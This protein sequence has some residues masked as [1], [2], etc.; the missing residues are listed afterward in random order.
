MIFHLLDHKVITSQAPNYHAQSRKLLIRIHKEPP[1]IPLFRAPCCI[2]MVTQID[3]GKHLLLWHDMIICMPANIQKSHVHVII[4]RKWMINSQQCSGLDNDNS[5]QT[6]E[7]I[8]FCQQQKHTMSIAL[9]WLPCK[10]LKKG[11][12]RFFQETVWVRESQSTQWPC[13][14]CTSSHFISPRCLPAP[15]VTSAAAAQAAPLRRGDDQPCSSHSY[16]CS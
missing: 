14:A 10:Q 9:L 2:S 13:T 12:D 5:I 1:V 3:F 4:P 8:N 7:L 11:S 15:V 16:P 6:F